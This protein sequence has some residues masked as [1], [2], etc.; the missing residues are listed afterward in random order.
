MNDVSVIIPVFNGRRYL[1]DAIRSVLAQT[2]VPR[3]IVVVDDG[4]TDDSASLARDLGVT[5]VSQHHAGQ[6]AALNHGIARSQGSAVAF[7]DADDVW[8]PN[9]LEL[10]LEVLAGSVPIDAVFGHAVQFGEAIADSPPMP[11]RLPSALLVRRV[12]LQ[13][14]GPFDTELR[15]GCPVEWAIRLEESGVGVAMLPQVLYRRRLHGD[16][17]GRIHAERRGDYLDIVRR[18]LRRAAT[19]REPKAC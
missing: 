16:N 17:S 2:I 19:L 10:Q 12:T 11:A 5:C 13:R 15:L 7:L 9:K 4:S 3:E 14:V 8:M 1:R 18:K 6:G